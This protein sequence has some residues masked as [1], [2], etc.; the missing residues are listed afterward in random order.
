MR[1]Q[2]TERGGPQGNAVRQDPRCMCGDWF[3]VEVRESAHYDGTRVTGQIPMLVCPT[4]QITAMPHGIGRAIRAIIGRARPPHPPTC[5]FYPNERR[6]DLCKTVRFAYS[7]ID[8]DVIPGLRGENAADGY[9]VPVFFDRSILT[10]FRK[11]AQHSVSEH[12]HA[13]RIVFPDGS[14]LEYGINRRGR[15]FCWLGDLDKIPVGAQRDMLLANVQ[16]DSDVISN[17]YK[18]GRLGMDTA[19]LAEEKLK[20]S[21]YE[22]SRVSETALGFGIHRLEYV[23][24][25]VAEK[26]SRPETW[27]GDLTQA[28]VNLTKLCIESIDVKNLK[29]SLREEANVEGLHGLKTMETWIKV[30]LSADPKAVMKPF[31]VLYDWRNYQTHRQ[32]KSLTDGYLECRTRMGLR[33]DEKDDKRMYDLLLDSLASSCRGLADQ[34]RMGPKSR[35]ATVVGMRA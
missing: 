1:S 31:F 20:N 22:L 34:I 11:H 9:Y 5:V 17:H 21:V 13:D 23:D 8:L 4:C 19:N 12:G 6:F 27:D 7:G 25:N 26:M 32:G 16:S 14:E 30:V 33:K 29:N 2:P 35:W 3:S 24:R 28:L 18:T 15:V 10:R